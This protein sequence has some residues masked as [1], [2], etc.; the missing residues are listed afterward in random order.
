MQLPAHALQGGGGDD[1]LRGA[2]DAV[3][4]VHARL[5]PGGR[6]GAGDVA[7]GD[8]LD[9]CAGLADLGDE[10]A[11]AVTVENL[12][13]QIPHGSALGAGDGVEVVRR[14]GIEIDHSDR[15]G[16][17]GEL[18]HV[19]ARTRVE[20]GAPVGH[21]DDSE[22]AAATECA[23]LGAVD[24]VDGDV[25]LGKAAVADS[26]AV[27][28]HGGFV[29]LTLA[30]DD[31]TV[32]GDGL[33]DHPHGVDGGGVRPFLV[34]PPEPPAGSERSRLRHADELHGE[35]AI[36]RLTVRVRVVVWR[37]LAPGRRR[38]S[39]CKAHRLPTIL[40]RRPRRRPLLA[41]KV[42]RGLDRDSPGWQFV[43]RSSMMLG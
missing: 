21:G 32:H 16:A 10:L 39:G 11:V 19:E 34:S 22:G 8:E 9:T 23:Q 4:N 26:L 20:H 25:G 24:R 1:P 35:V 29:L 30:D 33:E 2:A 5:R 38:V 28:E 41:R 42:K 36:G 3:E 37:R 6:D 43:V 17:D 14:G 40:G 12:H 13:G 31:D 27:E 18:L 15:L 7:G